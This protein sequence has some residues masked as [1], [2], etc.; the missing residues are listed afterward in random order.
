MGSGTEI[1]HASANVLLIGND[2]RK[3]AATLKTARWCRAV[4]LQKV[5]TAFSR[6]YRLRRDA[7][8]AT[9]DG[10]KSEWVTTEWGAAWILRRRITPLLYRCDVDD[11]PRRMQHLQAIDWHTYEAYLTRVLQRGG[12]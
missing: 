2:L 1:A 8:L 3:F 10:L 6:I 12:D 11:L 4:I 5:G 9:R 7:L